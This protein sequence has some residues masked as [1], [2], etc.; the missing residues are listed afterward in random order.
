MG[1]ETIHLTKPKSRRRIEIVTDNDDDWFLY[2]NTIEKSSEKLVYSSMII[3]KD[4]DHR[5]DFL[6]RSGWL[7]TESDI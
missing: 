4:L 7:K 6:L 1:N 3:R 2:V 5:L